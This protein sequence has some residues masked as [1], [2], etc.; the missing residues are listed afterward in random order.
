M[1]DY[2][3][4]WRKKRVVDGLKARLMAGVEVSW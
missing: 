3:A 1:D 2:E 4:F